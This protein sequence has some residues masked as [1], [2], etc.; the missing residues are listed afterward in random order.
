MSSRVTPPKMTATFFPVRARKGRFGPSLVSAFLK[1]TKRSREQGERRG[2]VS[3]EILHHQLTIVCTI[4]YL[5]PVAVIL[6]LRCVNK[7]A[8]TQLLAFFPGAGG[9]VIPPNAVLIF[10][11]TLEKLDKDLNIET[12]RDGD[13]SGDQVVRTNDKVHLHYVATLIDGKE[14]DNSYKRGEPLVLPV[15]KVL[16]SACF[17]TQKNRPRISYSYQD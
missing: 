7:T 6:T 8:G 9:G 10:D 12:V 17:H 2:C 14:F 13:C 16:R 3:W 5:R 11:V 4:Y 15:G 1:K